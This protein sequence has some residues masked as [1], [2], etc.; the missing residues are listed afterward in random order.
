MRWLDGIPNS[1]DVRLSKLQGM[2]KNREAWRAAVHEAAKSR[3]RLSDC[4]EQQQSNH[5]G[6]QKPTERAPNGQTWNKLSKKIN[7]L[8]LD[9][10]PK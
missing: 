3:T 4:L 2:V 5:K 1:M 6:A 9:Y 7:N 8:V 10:N